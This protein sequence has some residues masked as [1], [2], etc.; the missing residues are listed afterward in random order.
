MRSRTAC[1]LA[2][3]AA[4]C[5]LAL[6]GAQASAAG[7]RYV[8]DG[9]TQA[10]RD[11]VRQALEASAFDWGLI[12]G[13]L[14]VHIRRG[15]VS[16]ASPRHVWLDAGLLETGQFAWGVV[17]HEFAHQVDYLL[18]RP[19]D[20]DALGQFLGGRTW[21]SGPQGIEHDE[22]GCERFATSLAVG[23]WP[24]A[25]NVFHPSRSP[26]ERWLRP[27]AFRTMLGGLLGLRD[28][29][30]VRQTLSVTRLAIGPVP[31]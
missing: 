10:H 14:T 2:L 24:S 13:T 27:G 22:N 18:L 15:I 12:P 7:G 16:Q 3:A 11:Q 1:L 29:F 21:C 9:G 25:A 20:R 28:P 26:D 30:V 31:Q 6:S 8:F 19:E 5:G 23:Y 17:Q 4:C